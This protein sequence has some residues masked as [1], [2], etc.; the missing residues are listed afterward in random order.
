MV[1]AGR[2]L[3]VKEHTRVSLWLGTLGAEKQHW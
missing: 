2:D 1:G 3:C